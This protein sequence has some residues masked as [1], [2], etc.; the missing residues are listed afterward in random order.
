MH[1]QQRFR[2]SLCA[3]GSQRGS[4]WAVD[5]ESAPTSTYFAGTL[6]AIRTIH[7]ETNRFICVMDVEIDKRAVYISLVNR[8]EGR[9]GSV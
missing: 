5:S 3:L 8:Y 2:A 9:I 6:N 1:L 7:K 4:S